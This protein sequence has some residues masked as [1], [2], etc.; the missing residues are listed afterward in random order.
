M[1]ALW[2]SSEGTTQGDPLA[3]PMYALASIPL[4]N[5]AIYIEDVNQV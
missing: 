1:A 4:I 3:T 2:V 5:T